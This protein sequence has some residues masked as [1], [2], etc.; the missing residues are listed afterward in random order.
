MTPIAVR[1]RVDRYQPMVEPACD[2]IVR[3]GV[4]LDPES[5]ICNEVVQVLD[6]GL[7]EYSYVLQRL[8]ESSRPPPG[9]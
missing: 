7:R 5:R 8:S 4:V 9:V 1:K 2:F 3:I 6:D